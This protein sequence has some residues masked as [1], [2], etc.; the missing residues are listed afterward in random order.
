M[1]LQ[2]LEATRVGVLGFYSKG[3]DVRAF[4]FVTC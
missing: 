1:T 4:V 3:Q 2:G